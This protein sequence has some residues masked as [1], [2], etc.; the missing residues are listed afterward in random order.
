ML[1]RECRRRGA[2]TEDFVRSSVDSL[3]PRRRGRLGS[4]VDVPTFLYLGD[5][6]CLC[7]VDMSSLSDWRIVATADVAAG[8]GLMRSVLVLIDESF[9]PRAYELGP[10]RA[11][12]GDSIGMGD[13]V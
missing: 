12:R 8:V 13:V 2:I 1:P 9:G 5:S 6:C 10:F 7:L 11:L 4:E 3:C